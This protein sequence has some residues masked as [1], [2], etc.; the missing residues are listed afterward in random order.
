MKWLSRWH[1]GSEWTLE[2]VFDLKDLS[3]HPVEKN[4]AAEFS[5]IR[6][7]IFIGEDLLHGGKQRWVLF[8]TVSP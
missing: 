5:Q 8:A 1:P 7:D 4:D 6:L 2:V 3:V